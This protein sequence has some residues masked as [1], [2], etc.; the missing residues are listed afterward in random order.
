MTCDKLSFNDLDEKKKVNLDRIKQIFLG[1]L[2]LNKFCLFHRSIDG[3]EAII[4]HNCECKILPLNENFTDGLITQTENCCRKIYPF[5]CNSLEKLKYKKSKIIL[6][7]FV[8]LYESEN[9]SK[10]IEDIA[11]NENIANSL[12]MYDSISADH[13]WQKVYQ[14]I[15]NS[16]KNIK[17]IKVI[18]GKI[19]CEAL[20]AFENL[21]VFYAAYLTYIPSDRE[22]LDNNSELRLEGKLIKQKDFRGQYIVERNITEF[23]SFVEV[24]LKNI[25]EGDLCVYKFCKSLPSYRITTKQINK[26]EYGFISDFEF[27]NKGYNKLENTTV[28]IFFP[29]WKSKDN[30]SSFEGIVLLLFKQPPSSRNL[31]N[32]RRFNIAEENLQLVFENVIMKFVEE[33]AHV[34][35]TLLV[36][37][38]LDL[39]ETKKQIEIRSAKFINCEN[40]LIKYDPILAH[41][42]DYFSTIAEFLEEN[43]TS[44]DNRKLIRVL[45]NKS[46]DYVENRIEGS[47]YSSLV[48]PIKSL[49]G[50]IQGVVLFK[51][52]ISSYKKHRIPFSSDDHFLSLH[53]VHSIGN[54]LEIANIQKR[55]MEFF[56]MAQHEITNAESVIFGSC[57]RIFE[58]LQSRS[59]E[60]NI[61]TALQLIDDISTNTRIATN[62]LLS[63]SVKVIHNIIPDT[64]ARVGIYGDIV[65]KWLKTFKNKLANKKV[66]YFATPQYEYEKYVPKVRVLADHLD[67]LFFNLIGNAFK[68]CARNS[69]VSVDYSMNE[70]LEIFITNYGKAWKDSEQK[71]LFKME[72]RASNGVKEANGIGLGLYIVDKICDAYKSMKIVAEKPIKLSEYNLSNAIYL[73]DKF[74]SESICTDSE[75]EIIDRDISRLTDYDKKRICF[76][77]DFSS[78]KGI[79]IGPMTRLGIISNPTYKIQFKII[80]DRKLLWI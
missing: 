23:N 65:I 77:Q 63:G 6:P 58:L 53:L 4:K 62:F 5:S 52:K 73:F 29:V 54:I 10:T 76:L 20:K 9:E 8:L 47:D 51:K 11:S 70:H 15:R 40:V 42:F 79:K 59:I 69:S 46:I 55:Q 60:R 66:G 14:D 71:N 61:D 21:N 12:E 75:K 33:S 26:F 17:E 24:D 19:Y 25:N 45:R 57:C 30:F 72:F 38:Q 50:N 44:I 74:P 2:E 39:E 41:S 56:V 34:Y 36:D 32:V 1:Q 18:D 78:L 16:S 35:Q 31:I 68:Y 22:L 37:T 7:T 3:F 48:F 28:A 13:V 27:K 49:N 43:E 67:L 64:N 80:F